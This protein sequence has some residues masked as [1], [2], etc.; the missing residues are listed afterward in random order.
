MYVWLF[1]YLKYLIWYLGGVRY[2]YAWRGQQ[3]RG[4]RIYIYIY[5]WRCCVCMWEFI[6]LK[7]RCILNVKSNVTT[8][9]NVTLNFTREFIFLNSERNLFFLD[10]SLRELM[11]SVWG[12]LFLPKRLICESLFLSCVCEAKTTRIRCRPL[13]SLSS[14]NKWLGARL[15]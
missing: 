9:C 5:I 13:M 3:Y 8:S 6:F 1:I 14:Q 10:W 11:F 15:F 7:W 4:S 12:S 2:I